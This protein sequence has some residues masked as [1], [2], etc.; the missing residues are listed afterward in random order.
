MRLLLIALGLLAALPVE[1]RPV[2]L[3]PLDARGV[4]MDTA[5]AGT[6]AALNG[7]KSLAGVEVI[8]PEVAE[9]N[10]GIQLTQQARGCEYEVFCL[11]EVGELLGAATVLIGHVQRAAEGE[12][13]ELK[14]VV[15]DVGK[16][17]ITEVLVWRLLEGRTALSGAVATAVR[18]LFSAPDAQI[19]WELSPANARI[20]VYGEPL[21]QGTGALPYW[22]GRYHL[23]IEAEGY[24]PLERVVSLAPGEN[25]VPFSLEPD[26]LYVPTR[27]APKT[28]PFDRTSRR[29]GSGVGAQE[30]GAQAQAR[31][32][33]SGFAKPIPWL[34]VGAGAGATVLGAIFMSSAQGRYNEFSGQLRYTPGTT[35]TA[36][37]ARREREDAQGAFR[38]GEIVLWSGVAVAVGALVWMV[39]DDLTAESEVVSKPKQGATDPVVK[40]AVSGLVHDA[41]GPR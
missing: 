27:T 22:S 8:D 25:R 40:R 26:P 29:E 39:V 19:I 31:P 18:R 1:A 15:L 16:A 38:S 20:L 5:Q 33:T 2:V 12:A 24:H 14:L 28:G 37:V 21:D 3:F 23:R 9:R 34:V 41:W 11:V 30:A 32:T 17:R 4:A 10:L 36:D 13:L 35:V 7:L 6:S